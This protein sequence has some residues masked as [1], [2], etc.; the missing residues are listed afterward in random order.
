MYTRKKEHFFLLCLQKYLF[1]TKKF[2]GASNIELH[3][4]KRRLHERRYY[5]GVYDIIFPNNSLVKQM[6]SQ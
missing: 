1:N 3:A 5:A 2:L 6:Y 4:S